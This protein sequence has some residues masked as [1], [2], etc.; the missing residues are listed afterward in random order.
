M[1][2]DNIRNILM[3]KTTSLCL[4]FFTWT[5]NLEEKFNRQ[6]SKDKIHKFITYSPVN[7]ML[8]RI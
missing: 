4:P 8:F 7:R 2:F 5:F 3:F 6:F 1:E